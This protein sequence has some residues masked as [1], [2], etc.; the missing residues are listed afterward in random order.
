MHAYW[1]HVRGS[2]GGGGP[3]PAIHTAHNNKRAL[4]IWMKI[5]TAMAV[6]R[7]RRNLRIHTTQSEQS[8]K[9]KKNLDTARK[10]KKKRH[11]NI[12]YNRHIDEENKVY[13][14]YQSAIYI[15]LVPKQKTYSVIFFLCL[16]IFMFI[17]CVCDSF[18]FTLQLI[19]S[20][21]VVDIFLLFLRF[22][23]CLG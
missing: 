11:N 23:K 13:S 21:N 7:Q 3:R 5:Y 9:N 2:G 15:V 10:K 1:T 8:H 14:P 19:R 18:F 16:F 12:L 4:Q 17:N 20:T 22:S 6:C